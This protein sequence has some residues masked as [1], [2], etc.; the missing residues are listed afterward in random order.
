MRR[1]SHV[2]CDGWAT[3]HLLKLRDTCVARVW[4]GTWAAL[5]VRVREEMKSF[6]VLL[7]LVVLLCVTCEGGWWGSSHDHDPDHDHHHHDTQESM[8]EEDD[9][10]ITN[11]V[12]CGSLIKLKHTATGYRLH[13]HQVSYG[14]GSGQQSV[15]TISSNDDPN[16]FW[17][18]RGAQ[19]KKRCK[20]GY[21]LYY[22]YIILYL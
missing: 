12:T 14:S 11:Y 8:E 18:V 13:S 2:A 16:S 1:Q 6:V 19:G 22:I 3:W 15:T 17:M 10:D 9:P 7:L 21:L 20:Q 4:E 5:R